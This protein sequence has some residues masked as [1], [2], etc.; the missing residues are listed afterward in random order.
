MIY[1]AQGKT[2]FKTKTINNTTQPEWKE[3]CV[4]NLVSSFMRCCFFEVFEFAVEQYESDHVNFEVF[5][6]DPGKDDFIGRYVEDWTISLIIS[7]F[8]MFRAQF[9]LDSLVGKDAIDTVFD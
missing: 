6:E 2:E 7:F 9:P 1:S 8:L 4:G 5:D 3:V